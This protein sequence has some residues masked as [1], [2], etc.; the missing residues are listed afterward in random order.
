MRKKIIY[1]LLVLTILSCSLICLNGVNAGVPCADD[2]E[3]VVNNAIGKGH[4]Q[5]YTVN[6]GDAPVEISY[7]MTKGYLLR[8]G[9][10]DEVSGS[11]TIGPE[12]TNGASW[13][14][15]GQLIPRGVTI[16]V[17]YAD[18][19]FTAHGIGFGNSVIYYSKS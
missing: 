8:S 7:V 12:E 6:H 18:Y 15:V 3:I 1:G 19:T 13:L 9:D 11:Y 16:S 14:F 17:S 5:F 2:V 4:V 10:I